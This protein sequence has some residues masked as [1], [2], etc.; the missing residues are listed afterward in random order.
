MTADIY[1]EHYSSESCAFDEVDVE[2]GTSKT[3]GIITVY[4]NSQG[5][6][7]SIVCH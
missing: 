2:E 3:G 5:N 1:R 4:K 6:Y 7:W